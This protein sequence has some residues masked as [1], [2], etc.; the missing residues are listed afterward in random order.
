MA[1]AD[2]ELPPPS[3]PLGGSTGEGARYP[4]F[5]Y[6]YTWLD[7][8]LR[9][10]SMGSPWSNPPLKTAVG[11]VTLPRPLGAKVNALHPGSALHVS[12]ASCTQ[13]AREGGSASACWDQL[14]HQ[15]W[16][17]HPAL[18]L[19]SS[20][21]SMP[22]PSLAALTMHHMLSP[23]PPHAAPPHSPTH[24]LLHPHPRL[25]APPKTW[26]VSTCWATPCRCTR[27]SHIQRRVNAGGALYTLGQ[28]PGRVP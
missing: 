17:P 19:G 24:S 22:H 23:A 21:S 9:C 3:S 7:K 13:V 1:P 25:P 6:K 8:E 5:T 2:R 20:P 4:S 16:L 10:R 14:P 12:L 27:A 15:A 11:S 26:T 18:H 28:P